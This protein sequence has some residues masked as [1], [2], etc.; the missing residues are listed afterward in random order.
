MDHQSRSLTRENA[1]QLFMKIRLNLATTPLENNRKFITGW[2]MLGAM[3]LLAFVLLFVHAFRGRRA[4]TQ[5]RNEIARQE[6]RIS[7]LAQRQSALDA[8]FKSPQVREDTDR[9]GF[10]NSLIE[11]RSFPWT[12]IFMDLEGTLPPG[13]RVVNIAPKM[14]NGRVRVTL[15]V[16]ALSDEGKLKF[17][18]ALEDSKVFSQI[19]VREEIHPQSTGPAGGA[20]DRVM[21]E[22]VALYSTS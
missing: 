1:S 22:L 5:L 4:N 13:V 15:L 9:A 20:N 19:Q 3:A 16:G 11:Q 6:S 14:E 7:A 17:L 2:S 18:K 12:K 10:L 8:F 21:L